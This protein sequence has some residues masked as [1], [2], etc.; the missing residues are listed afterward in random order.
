MNNQWNVTFQ[1]I[2]KASPQEMLEILETFF[3]ASIPPSA[4][5]LMQIVGK[6]NEVLMSEN[7]KIRPSDK[8]GNPGGF[9]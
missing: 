3:T 2:S 8:N 1:F 9:I 5:M 4:Q 6:V 7:E